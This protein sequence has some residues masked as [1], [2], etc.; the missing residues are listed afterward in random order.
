MLKV[1]CI[2]GTRCL[3]HRPRQIE[4]ASVFDTTGLRLRIP[5]P[6]GNKLL[7]QKARKSLITQC[8]KEHAK[9]QS[10]GLAL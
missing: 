2:E 1:G 8:C 6:M 5:V 3:I 10:R 7:D 9:K 4:K